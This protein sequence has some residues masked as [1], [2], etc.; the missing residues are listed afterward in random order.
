MKCPRTGVIMKEVAIGHFKIDICE[1]CAGI[2]FDHLEFEKFDEAHEKTG[3]EV[4]K[5]LESISKFPLD[6]NRRIHCPRCID[7]VLMRRFE[8]PLKKIALDECPSCGGLW[9]DAGELA[10]YRKLFPKEAD[11]KKASQEFV[12]KEIMPLFKK[13]AQKGEDEL[14]KAKHIASMFRLVC[15]SFYIPGKQEGAAF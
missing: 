1:S 3:E 10:E 14:K 11:R 8:S 9:L 5:L 12:D 15:P 6:L 4:L 13:E 7:A 2:W